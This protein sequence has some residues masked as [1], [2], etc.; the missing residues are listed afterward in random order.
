MWAALSAAKQSGW[1]GLVA[2]Q[3][4]YLDT[5][6]HRADVEVDGDAEVPVP[7]AR[8]RPVSPRDASPRQRGPR[9]EGLSAIEDKS[10]AGPVS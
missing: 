5:F 7:A 4:G 1:D 10:A 9:D 3:R 2:E 8:P 6:W